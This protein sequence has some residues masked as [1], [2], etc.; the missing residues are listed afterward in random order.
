MKRKIM[1]EHPP[2][3]CIFQACNVIEDSIGI[4]FKQLEDRHYLLV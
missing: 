1:E 2:I 3:G 4:Q